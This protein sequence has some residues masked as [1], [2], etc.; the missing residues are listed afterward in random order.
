MTEP[1]YRDA[2]ITL[3]LGDMRE[4]TAWTEADVLVTDPPYGRRWHQGRARSGR[5]DVDDSYL[6]IAGDR[7]TTTRDAALAL[8]GDRHTI[9]FGDLMLP[10]PARTRQ[11]LVYRKGEGSG[12]KGTYAGFRR[13]VEAVYLVGPWQVGLHGR[14][15]VIASNALA[16]AGRYGVTGRHRHPHAKPE[17]VMEALIGVCPEGTIADPF[18][19]SG[20]TL[21][22]ARHRGRAAIGVEIDERWCEQA[23]RRLSQ[24]ALDLNQEAAK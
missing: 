4:I 7:D 6:R 20:S 5:N 8:F 14:T 2:M 22:A 1:Y 23:A 18:A 9:M 10:P 17:D 12:N 21:I 24:F 19:G 15:S 13:D 11:V 3:Y 16:H